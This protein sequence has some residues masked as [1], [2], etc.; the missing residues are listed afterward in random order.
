MILYILS[1]FP[2]FFK[3][4]ILD[5]NEHFDS[6]F[7]FN[8]NKLYNFYFISFDLRKY[9]IFFI[10]NIYIYTIHTHTK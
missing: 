2:F 5:M 4:I 8:P 9:F 1:L 10:Y 6:N 3:I 7:I